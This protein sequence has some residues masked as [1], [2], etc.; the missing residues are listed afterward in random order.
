M[1]INNG[2]LKIGI[3]TKN[4]IHERFKC[5]GLIESDVT[6]LYKEQMDSNKAVEKETH[7]KNKFFNY[8]LKDDIILKNFNG[9][10]ECF[11]KKYKDEILSFLQ[12]NY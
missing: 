3:T 2:I 12:I 10:T 6:I 1:N 11:D 9:K 7:I 5:E 8:S 4:N